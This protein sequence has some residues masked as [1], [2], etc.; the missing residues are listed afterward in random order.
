MRQVLWEGSRGQDACQADGAC[1]SE[2]LTC[3]E[4]H[5]VSKRLIHSIIPQVVLN[6]HSVLLA[7]GDNG[8]QHET[9]LLPSWT[10][11]SN[12]EERHQSLKYK[13]NTTDKL[14]RKICV[15]L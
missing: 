14:E 1:Y 3:A 8:R 2:T 9:S 5:L 7:S 13:Y 10:F 4:W 6:T 11:L 12:K 15:V